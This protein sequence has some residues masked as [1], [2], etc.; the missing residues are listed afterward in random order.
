MDDRFHVL[1]DIVIMRP[2]RAVFDTS[3][4]QPGER[5]RVD[6]IGY[7]QSQRVSV[8]TPAGVPTWFIF[9]FYERVAIGTRNGVID[10]PP[11]TMIICDPGC[12][13]IHGRRGE[14]WRRTWL[15]C[16]GSEVRA[17]VAEA[18]LPLRTV[19]AFN[20][21]EENERGLLAIHQELNHPLGADPSTV[22]DLF[23]IWMRT[24]RRGSRLERTV[25]VPAAFI[26]AR[27]Y[28]QEHWRDAFSLAELA[29][30]CHVSPSHLCKGFQK[31]FGVSPIS[32]AID[33]KLEQAKELLR[34]V[35]LNITEVALECGFADIF[36]FSRM[37]KKRV[38]FGPKTYRQRLLAGDA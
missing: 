21:H 8:N 24:A 35:D 29:G 11:H 3:Q 28:I 26:E 1:Y 34:D 20:D 17:V 4:H 25:R 37:F 10:A 14:P 30:A 16:G 22:L 36:Y 5:F 12:P 15:R 18:G 6:V 32:Y 9:M 31:H 7:R 27:A 33:L 13:V 38:G 19:I 23:R 2:F